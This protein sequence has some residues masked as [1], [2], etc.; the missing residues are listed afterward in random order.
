M[1]SILFAIIV[2]TTAI[3]LLVGR[4]LRKHKE[5]LKEPYGALQAALLGVVG[6]ILAFGLTMAVGRYETRRSAVVDDANAIGTAYLRAQTL[7]EPQRSES[8]ALMRRY[9]DADLQ[10]AHSI[11]NSPAARAAVVDGSLI[12][13]RLWNLAG[14]ALDGAPNANSTRLYVD[15]LN[16]MI[17]M[18]TVR[19]ASLNNRIPSEVLILEIVGAAV[20]LGLLALYLA[21][22]GR[23]VFTVAV[24]GGA[25]DHAA[26][27]HVRPR[28]ADPR[29]HHRSRRG[30]HEPARLD[31]AAARISGPERSL[32]PAR[33]RRQRRRLRRPVDSRT[34]GPGPLLPLD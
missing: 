29:L 32:R 18:Q 13:R 16:S 27:R 5:T 2:G 3:G 20:A 25:R 34:D 10:L 8:L 26:A 4:S 33:R 17:D 19:V 31:G 24:R 1:G 22:I 28:P 23:G 7:A 12:Q 21:I 11:P 30:A 15:S 9:T 6:L 14:Q